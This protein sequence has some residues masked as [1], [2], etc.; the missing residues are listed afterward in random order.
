MMRDWREKRRV[1]EDTV[2]CLVKRLV[3]ETVETDNAYVI[4]EIYHSR[5]V[6]KPM[7]SLIRRAMR[8]IASFVEK[9]CVDA[10]DP[11]FRNLHEL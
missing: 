9:K 11:S 2:S 7:P 1:K 10:D 6:Y 5:K 8:D 3:A 4:V